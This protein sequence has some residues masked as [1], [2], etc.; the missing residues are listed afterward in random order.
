MEPVD[1]R[2]PPSLF[3]QTRHASQ[4]AVWVA[5]QAVANEALKTKERQE[6]LAQEADAKKFGGGEAPKIDF[7]YAAPPGLAKGSDA[8]Q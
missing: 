5:Q 2:D 1:V 7:M 4:K 3:T 8:I 6:E